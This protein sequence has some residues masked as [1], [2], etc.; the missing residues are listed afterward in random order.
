MPNS[1]RQR[2][3]YFE[4]RVRETLEAD[5]WLVI[6]A[7]GSLGPA[8]LWAAKRNHRLRIV[9]C[10]LHGTLPRKEAITLCDAADKS[11]A[12]ALLA[13]RNKPGWVDLAIITRRFGT[14]TTDRTPLAPMRMPETRRPKYPEAVDQ[15]TLDDAI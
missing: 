8:D 6:R 2:G 9:S 15:L 7:A 3:D 11:G 13:S 14:D 10:K 5:G 4:R 12:I 1:N